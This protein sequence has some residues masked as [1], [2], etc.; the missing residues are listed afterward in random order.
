MAAT[1]V[2]PVIP[3]FN[4]DPTVCVVQATKTTPAQYFLSTSTFEYFPGAPIYHSTDL[5]N[6]TL[7]GHALGRRSQIDLRTVEPGAGCWATTLRYRPR[8]RRWYLTTGLFHRYRPAADERIFPR[9]FYVH[10]GNIWDDAAWSDPVYFDNPGFDQDLFWD[11]DGK[12]YLSTTT[13]MARRTPGPAL[14]DFAIHVSEIDLA[15]GRS[16]TP[17]RMVRSSPSGVAEGSHLFCRGFYYYLL[18]AEGGTEA[19]H[20]EWVFRSRDG[21]YGPWEG[22]GRPLWYNGPDEE[23]QRTGHCD[24]FE[25][26][27]GGWWGVMLGVR[28]LRS[29]GRWLEPQLGRETFLVKVDWEDDWPVFNDGKNVSLKTAGRRQVVKSSG[30]DKDGFKWK[31]DLSRRDLELGWYHKSKHELQRKPDKSN[32]SQTRR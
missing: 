20:Q 26:G 30:V 4:P 23:V 3:G 22:Q 31:A 7:I 11:D 32:D 18:T 13:R 19:G 1:L 16:L 5:V 27:D 12:V 10:T 2:N 29:G 9:G 6:W 15:S 25:D 28:P 17:P 21:P 8:E 24:V 14:K